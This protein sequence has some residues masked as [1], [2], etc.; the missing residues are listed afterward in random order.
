MVAPNEWEGEIE[1]AADVVDVDGD[2]GSCG[3]MEPEATAEEVNIEEE[4][5]DAETTP[6]RIAPD[7][8]QPSRKQMADHRIIHSL[9]RIVS[10]FCV[11]GRGRGNPRG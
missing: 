5:L 8:D 6:P 9:Y 4:Q 7:P 10:K 3:P 2:A 1:V 11:M